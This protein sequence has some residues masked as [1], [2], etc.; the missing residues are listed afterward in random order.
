[1][2]SSKPTTTA[3]FIKMWKVMMVFTPMSARLRYERRVFH[4]DLSQG[5]KITDWKKL[6]H[7]LP[8]L[9]YTPPG[10][11]WK[12]KSVSQWKKAREGGATGSKHRPAG[13]TLLVFTILGSNE[14]GE[15]LTK[16]AVN[17]IKTTAAHMNKRQRLWSLEIKQPWNMLTWKKCPLAFN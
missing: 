4:L 12:P 10:A 2:V 15:F 14:G 8:P 1:M 11:A 3:A 7:P 9:A 17:W 6:A 16:N 5:S 13:F